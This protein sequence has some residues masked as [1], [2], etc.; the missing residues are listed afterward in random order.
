MCREKKRLTL[1]QV[2]GHGQTPPAEL[3]MGP[4]RTNF[5]RS[6]VTTVTNPT[7][8]NPR[9]LKTVPRI[10]SGVN[11]Q[12][13]TTTV[14]M[15]NLES[16][17]QDDYLMTDVLDDDADIDVVDLIHLLDDVGYEDDPASDEE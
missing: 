12:T 1:N 5:R 10:V 14:N 4:N 8:I 13:P 3:F 7:P 15:V 9:R 16:V 2:L 17:D 6:M 11:K